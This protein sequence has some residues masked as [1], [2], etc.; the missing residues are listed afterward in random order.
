MVNYNCPRC[1]YTTTRKTNI[2]THLNRKTKCPPDI[3]DI[4]I[5]QMKDKIL[6]GTKKN[7]MYDLNDKLKTKTENPDEIIEKL[8][9]ENNKLKTEI[10]DKGYI[11]VL[12]N[13]MFGPNVYKIGCSA[14]PERR[15]KDYSTAY[16][17]PCSLK[18][19]S[20]LFDYKYNAE[21]KIFKLIDKYRIRSNREF[22]NLELDELIN[23]IQCIEKLY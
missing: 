16:V 13:D 20:K 19:V 7:V 9:T 6:Q 15:L 23:N 12:H 8:I 1:G 3:N 4:D 22:F 11:Y 21:K 14:N 17:N 10:K 18:Y 5:S 2:K